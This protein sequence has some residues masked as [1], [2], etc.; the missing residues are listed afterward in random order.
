MPQTP[1]VWALVLHTQLE[2][3]DGVTLTVHNR[4][5][6]VSEVVDVNESHAVWANMNRRTV[7][8]IGDTL[9]I[10]VRDANGELIRTLHHEID[11]MDIRRTFTKLV[12]TA[13]DLKPRRTALLANYPNPFNPEVDTVSVG[14]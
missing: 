3:I 12:L 2:G 9:M 1:K 6:G 11:A 14:A 13:E 5:T 7:A 4:R 8:S 10:E